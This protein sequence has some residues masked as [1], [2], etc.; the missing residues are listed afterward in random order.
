MNVNR[1]GELSDKQRSQ[2]NERIQ[3]ALQE[4]CTAERAEEIREEILVGAYTHQ[5]RQQIVTWL[6]GGWPG[7]QMF[8]LSLL[9]A[10]LLLMTR[11]VLD[12]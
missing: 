6:V 1:S 8:T 9:E 2:Q 10:H 3:A 12:C 7:V 11:E 4:E 5:D